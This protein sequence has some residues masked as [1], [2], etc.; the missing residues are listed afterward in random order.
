MVIKKAKK[1]TW[2]QPV[3]L[4][5][6]VIFLGCATT[7]NEE[8]VAQ[9]VVPQENILQVGVTP[10]SPPTIF[11]E[12]DRVV[13]LE[14]DFANALAESIGKKARFV[15][16]GW[17]D[18]IPALL[19]KRIDIIMSGMSIT[20]MRESRISFTSPY[21]NAGQMALVRMPDLQFFPTEDSIKKTQSRVGFIE[22]TTGGFLVAQEF[23]LT[24]RKIPFPSSSRAVQALSEER[25][26]IFIDDAPV[27]WW[28]AATQEK[29]GLARI[30]I[31][32]TEEQLAWG[33]RKGD[34]ELLK[35]ANLFLETWKGDGRLKRAITKWM[36]PVP[37]ERIPD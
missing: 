14:V 35:A 20:E 3:F 13:G 18:L 11:Y 4:L 23:P 15:V 9:P 5:T 16:L 30:P 6:L 1:H 7:G 8:I 34:T 10:T 2:F 19:E 24:N 26:D 37:D 33:V 36:P 29:A 22:G 32:L 28:K 17:K 25:I 31:L 21:L 27:I 12:N